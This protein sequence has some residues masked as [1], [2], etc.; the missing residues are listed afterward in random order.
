MAN[1]R[2]LA[3]ALVAAEGVSMPFTT[4]ARAEPP[5][6]EAFVHI[7]SP[8]PVDLGRRTEREGEF[9]VVCTSPCDRALP[10]SGAYRIQAPRAALIADGDRPPGTPLSDDFALF[11]GKPAE[12]PRETIAFAPSSHSR[13]AVGFGLVIVGAP[14]WVAGVFAGI[15]NFGHGLGEGDRVDQTGPLIAI[16]VGVVMTVTGIALLVS[17][18]SQVTIDGRSPPR[19]IDPPMSPPEVTNIRPPSQRTAEDTGPRA[20]AVRG[21]AAITVPLFQMSF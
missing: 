17:R 18:D 9:T 2:R 4:T 21:P 13:S 15:V 14:T 19:A 8:E 11:P 6:N 20:E 10:L 1:S 7:D 3:M 12:T 16:A 5:S